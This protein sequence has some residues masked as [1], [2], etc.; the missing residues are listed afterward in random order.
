MA[1]VATMASPASLGG[2]TVR[3]CAPGGTD[4]TVPDIDA[5]QGRGKA[6]GEGKVVAQDIEQRQRSRATQQA[7]QIEKPAQKSARH[8]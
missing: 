1:Q 8:P 2:E 7:G 5:S 3:P 4:G 6:D